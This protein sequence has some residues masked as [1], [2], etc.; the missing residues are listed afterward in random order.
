MRLQFAL[1]LYCLLAG[2]LDGEWGAWTPWTQCPQTCGIPGGTVLKRTRLC[3]RPPPMNGGK[4][5]V[6]NG[7]ETAKAC[8]AEC[9]G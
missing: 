4:Q 9:P 2:P 5:C 6:G 7:T 3:N 1:C 8:F